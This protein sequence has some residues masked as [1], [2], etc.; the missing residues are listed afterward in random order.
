M[1]AKTG[2]ALLKV[3]AVV[4]LLAAVVAGVMF[5]LR[6]VAKVETVARGDTADIVS[7][8]VVVD[9]ERASPIASEVEGK[10]KRSNLEPGQAVKEGDVLVELDPTDIELEIERAEA[11]YKAAKTTSEIAAKTAELQQA[12]DQETFAEATRQHDAHKLA[13]ADFK[14][15]QRALDTAEQG[16]AKAKADDELRLAQLDNTVKVA[17]RKKEKMTIRAPFDG[18]ITT[19]N[20]RQNDLIGA[21]DPI[22]QII[23]DTQLVKAKISEENFP[24]VQVGQKAKVT[25]LGY[26][27]EAFP[28]T[29]TQKLPAAEADTQRYIAYLKVEL[30]KDRKLLP[31]LTGEVGI[32]LGE[33]KNVVR[34][35]RRAMWDGY[36][37][38]VEGGRA[39]EHKLDTGYTDYNFVEVK[40]GVKEGDTIIVEEVDR[41]QN[42]QRV[43]TQSASEAR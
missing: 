25:F 20:A 30:P 1:S 36:V 11:E 21:K 7:G 15:A 23:A 26:G 27:G 38:V 6:P 3:V 18:T 10:V 43:R 14:R 22:A 5:Y 33:H 9:A 39:F 13:D 24:K 34:V 16:R 28:A 19:V 37:F 35:P 42:G 40:S 31:N 12:T 8:S 2:S 32:V 41:F 17:R 4:A 29:V